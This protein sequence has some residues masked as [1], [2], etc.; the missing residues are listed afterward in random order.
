MPTH[1]QLCLFAALALCLTSCGGGS[2]SMTPPTDTTPA[3][4]AYDINGA[5]DVPKTFNDVNPDYTN[6]RNAGSTSGTLAD[7][8]GNL[9]NITY[10]CND[11]AARQLDMTTTANVGSGVQHYSISSNP[12]NISITEVAG[13]DVLGHAAPAGRLTIR[14]GTGCVPGNFPLTVTSGSQNAAGQTAT[15]N[16]LTINVHLF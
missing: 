15:G 5:N 13:N 7:R 10:A 4:I 16:T 12:A 1:P 11:I 8:N 14:Q 6:K 2:V 9:I 3:P